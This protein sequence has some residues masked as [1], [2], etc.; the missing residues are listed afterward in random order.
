MKDIIKQVLNEVAQEMLNEAESFSIPSNLFDSG[1]DEVTDELQKQLNTIDGPKLVNYLNS[2]PKNIVDVTITSSESKVPNQPPFQKPK[3]LAQSRGEKLKDFFE[4]NL[5]KYK[6]QVRYKIVPIIS[7]PAW[8]GKNK[9]DKKYKDA[10]FIKVS[11]QTSSEPVKSNIN[12]KNSQFCKSQKIEF[13]GGQGKEPKFLGYHEKFDVGLGEGIFNV[14]F[15][16]LMYPDRLIMKSGNKIIDTGFVCSNGINQGLFEHIVILS[17]NYRNHPNSPAFNNINTIINISE[18][19][20][21]EVLSLIVNTMKKEGIS[22]SGYN[23]PR[24]KKVVEDNFGQGKEI[25][26]IVYYKKSV[27]YSTLNKDPNNQF[28]EVGVFSP[29]ADTKF[30]IIYNCR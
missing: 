6:N 10:Q 27:G 2:N 19:P 17:A 23:N 3:S 25:Q 5:T 13:S 21:N 20:P 18:T 15:I 26:N 22:L 9:D 7:G 28:V 1:K 14:T 4:K 24:M 29:V 11:Y 16:P 8:D 30:N 12:F